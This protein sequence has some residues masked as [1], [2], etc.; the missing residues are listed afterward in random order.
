MALML[1]LLSF[2]VAMLATLNPVSICCVLWRGPPGACESADC[3]DTLRLMVLRLPFTS[4][5]GVACMCVGVVGRCWRL[6][7]GRCACMC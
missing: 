1:V 7:G 5:I 2:S 3:P 6:T 4:V